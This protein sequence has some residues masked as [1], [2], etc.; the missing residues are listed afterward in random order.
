MI[1]GCSSTQSSA[2]RVCPRCLAQNNH[3]QHGL[4]EYLADSRMSGQ[5]IVVIVID[6]CRDPAIS[7]GYCNRSQS[8]EP[9]VVLEI[10]G[11]LLH[12][13][14]LLFD[15]AQQRRCLA[16]KEIV[17]TLCEYITCSTDRA[18][19]VPICRGVLCDD[20]WDGG[21][22]RELC[23]PCSVAGTEV[24]LCPLHRSDVARVK[25][26][27]LTASRSPSIACT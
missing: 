2:R 10:A 13:A 21:V 8:S 1:D 22:K 11:T 24:S 7:S 14:I 5:K 23:V 18:Q 15:G 9:H 3:R 25:W 6:V 20:N 16:R 19:N 26:I 4:A 17:K 27:T 12:C